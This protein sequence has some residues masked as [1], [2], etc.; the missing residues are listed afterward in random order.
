VVLAGQSLKRALRIGSQSRL[1]LRPHHE[2]FGDTRSAWSRSARNFARI[3]R[4]HDFHN[5]KFSMKSSNPQ[6]DESSV[7]LLVRAT[8]A[9]RAGLE[10]P[11]STYGVTR[12]GEGEERT[13]TI[14]HRGI[15]SLLCDGLGDTQSASRSRK[16]LRGDGGVSVIVARFQFL[17]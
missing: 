17:A 1:T 15:G 7:S 14:R 2:R 12:T 9:G 8:G 5:F 4:K 11:D 6:G 16:I 10:L 13:H 3:A